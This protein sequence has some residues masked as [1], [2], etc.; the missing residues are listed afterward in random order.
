MKIL[1][2]QVGPVSTNAYIVYDEATLKGFVIDPGDESVAI[3]AEIGGRGL[4]IVAILVTHGHFDHIAAVDKLKAALEVD[5][6]ASELDAQ[7]CASVELNRSNMMGR[8]TVTCKIDKYLKDGEELDLGFAKIKA[9]HTP[10]HTHGHLCYYLLGQ[11]IIFTGDTLFKG[12]YGRHDL[13]TANFEYLKQS[14]G[15]LFELPDETKVY[16]GHG[17]S[18]TIGYEKKHNLILGE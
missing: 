13:P 12:T 17:P 16:P 15:K 5:V 1:V 11:N 3:Q 14:L 10:G 4:D 9:I 6:Y 18:S 2:M 7:I 8:E